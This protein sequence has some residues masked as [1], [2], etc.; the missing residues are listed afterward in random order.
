VELARACL[1]AHLESR[2]G[3]WLDRGLAE[4]ELATSMDSP[5]TE[6]FLVLAALQREARDLGAAIATLQRAVA[7]APASAEAHQKLGRALMAAGRPDEAEDQL[8][9]AIYLR[10]G[11][12]PDHHWLAELYSSQGRYDAAVNQYR[13]V[14]DLAPSY[15]GGYNNLGAM[16]LYLGRN[17]EARTA[18]EQSLAVDPDGNFYAYANLGTVYFSESRF[19]DSARMFQQALAIEDDVYWLWGNLGHS[20]ASG[21]EPE[22]AESPFRRAIELAEEARLESSE[23]DPMLLAR[24]AAYYASVGENKRGLEIVELASGTD[25]TDP[26]V[27]ASIAVAY[28]DLG[29]RDRALEW[30]AIAY[31]LGAL[32]SWFEGQPALRDLIADARYQRL[33]PSAPGLLQ[34]PVEK[35]D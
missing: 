4:A 5:S 23:A 34:D 7:N 10:P 20:Y 35:G 6:A 18:F 3:S 19:A 32:P 26:Q 12:W 8:Q 28:E 17:A 22:R 9:H 2:E 31:R 16:F 15:D 27:A 33:T 30:V 13:R 25:T 29:Q 11:F 21:I 14:V 24:L 1:S